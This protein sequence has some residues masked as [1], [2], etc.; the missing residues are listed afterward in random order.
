MHT[1]HFLSQCGAIAF[2]LDLQSP[3]GKLQW[4]G[5]EFLGEFFFSKVE[6]KV[7]LFK[8]QAET[9]AG[10]KTWDMLSPIFD[11]PAQVNR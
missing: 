6:S 4:A 8:N 3:W 1:P 10:A 5:D 9:G 2:H 11:L 7:S